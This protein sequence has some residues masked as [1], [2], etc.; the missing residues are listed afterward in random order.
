MASTDRGLDCG[1][2]TNESENPAIGMENLGPN[3]T[4]VLLTKATLWED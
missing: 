2:E 3:G 4:L 1:P